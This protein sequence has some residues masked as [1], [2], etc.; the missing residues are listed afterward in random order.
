M[1]DAISAW[2]L[3][4][5]SR[6]WRWSFAALA[7]LAA[8]LLRYLL[9]GIL[10]PG[11]PFLTFFPAVI[12]TTFFAGIRP[13]VAAGIACGLASWYFFIPPLRSVALTPSSALAMGFYVLIVATDILILHLMR[14]AAEGQAREMQRNAE[15]AESRRL[16]FHEL[17]HRVSNNLTA[18][19]S[20]LKLQRRQVA[21]AAARK[22]LDEA[23]NRIALIARMQRMLHDPGMQQIDFARFLQDMS[24]DLLNSAGAAGR[25]RCDVEAETV[26]IG[27]DQSVPLGLIATEFL[28]NA[29]EHAFPDGRAGQLRIRLS[30][31]CDSDPARALLEIHDDGVGLPSDFALDRTESLGLMIARQF[32]QQLDA[33]IA[34]IRHPDGGTVSRL[35][36]PMP[37]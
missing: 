31:D 19:A 7:S 9:D 18:V 8:F 10:P 25:I 33:D 32:A 13:G 17:Q 1:L 29:M 24:E 36:F 37:A 20:L 21:D 4:P 28:A 2:S 35:R 14:R 30:R 5:R 23:V 6:M 27:P 34:M 11:F 22:A 15:L 12:L 26:R 3:V 16:M